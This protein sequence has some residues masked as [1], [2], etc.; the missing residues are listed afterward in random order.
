MHDITRRSAIGS[1]AAALAATS[2]PVFTRPAPPARIFVLVHGAWHGGWVWRDVIDQLQ[3]RG[4]RAFAP[5]LTGLGERAHLATP[6]TDL[7]THIRDVCAVIEAEELSSVT[8]VGHSYA[9][10]VITGV[11]AILPKHIASLVYLDAVVPNDGECMFDFQLPGARKAARAAAIDGWLMSAPQ[12]AA[13]GLDPGD[14]ATGGWVARRMTTHPIKTWEQA[15]ALL[16]PLSLSRHFVH[17]IQPNLLGLFNRFADQ[18]AQTRGWRLTSLPTGHD[19]MVTRPD[20]VA[21]AIIS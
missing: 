12:V 18:A 14:P 13:L 19:A 17:C 1:V 21:R 9:G 8:L 15:L 5:T 6:A 7:N 2:G 20:L 10:M 3:R 4:H 11:A 16:K